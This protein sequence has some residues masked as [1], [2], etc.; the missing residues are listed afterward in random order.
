MVFSILDVD[1]PV[2]KVTYYMSDDGASML[3]FDTSVEIAEFARRWAPFCQKYSIE[4]RALEFYFSKKIE[5]LK[6]K[7][8]PNFAKDRRAMKVN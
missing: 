2:E 6:D 1:Y 8:Q 5:N 7:V 3:P 4:P